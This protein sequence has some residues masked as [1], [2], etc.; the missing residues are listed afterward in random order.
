MEQWNK[1]LGGGDNRNGPI[2][3]PKALKEAVTLLHGYY[4]SNGSVTYTLRK[5][6][7]KTGYG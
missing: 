2:H 7:L 1:N 6:T 3:H 4:I 5:L